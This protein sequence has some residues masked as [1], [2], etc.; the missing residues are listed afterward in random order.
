MVLTGMG[1]A[2]EATAAQAATPSCP[3][4][5]FCWY[6]LTTYEGT[7]GQRAAYSSS[8]VAMS[9]LANN[10]MSSYDNQVLDGCR[11]SVQSGHP[12]V[13]LGDTAGGSLVQWAMAWKR[14]DKYSSFSSVGTLG[15]MNNKFDVIKNYCG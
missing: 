2:V 3:T 4:G 13:Y 12:I 6:Y 9:S 8:F 5:Y 11:N 14:Y 15:N 10:S 7:R 1:A